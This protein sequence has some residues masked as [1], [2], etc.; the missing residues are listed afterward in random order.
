MLLV[1]NFKKNG[2]FILLRNVSNYHY[3]LFTSQFLLFY[4]QKK[5]KKSEKTA[6]AFLFIF[7]KNFTTW[8]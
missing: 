7:W 4:S 8:Q 1:N 5:E 3:Y 6:A 2:P